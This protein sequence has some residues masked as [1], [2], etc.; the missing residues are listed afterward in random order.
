MSTE[1]KKS[2]LN[3]TYFY[4]FVE[5]SPDGSHVLRNAI[6]FR[7]SNHHDSIKIFKELVGFHQTSKSLSSHIPLAYR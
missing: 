3:Q 4:R 7:F 6:Y 1:L 5:Q 2:G